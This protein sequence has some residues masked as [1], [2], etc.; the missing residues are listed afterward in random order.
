M[1]T[2]NDLTAAGQSDFAKPARIET[3]QSGG[4]KELR[5][6]KRI[7]TVALILNLGAAGVY[8]Q[9]KT[10]KMTFS[11]TS[12]SSAFKLTPGAGSSERQFRRGRYPGIIR[13]S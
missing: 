13:L 3:S 1:I 9:Q 10:V 8:A 11:G 6:W 12:E 7:A 5:V 2:K 4:R